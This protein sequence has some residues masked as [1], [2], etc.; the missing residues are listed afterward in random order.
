MH[1]PVTLALT[2]THP[3]LCVT[4]RPALSFWSYGSLI[5]HANIL[6]K[7]KKK[8]KSTQLADFKKVCYCAVAT[9]EST[10]AIENCQS[11]SYIYRKYTQA[12]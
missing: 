8:K 12:H 3:E 7:L 5:T 6:V 2:E 11:A 4:S 1:L 10:Q 9:T